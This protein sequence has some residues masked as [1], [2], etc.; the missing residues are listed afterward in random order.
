MSCS[1]CGRGLDER[2]N[3]ICPNVIHWRAWS[4]LVEKITT[5]ATTS[6]IAAW[7]RDPK[8]YREACRGGPLTG[9]SVGPWLADQLVKAAP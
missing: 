6:R 4:E 7:L 8:R 9:S 3:A 1:G 5:G 2:P